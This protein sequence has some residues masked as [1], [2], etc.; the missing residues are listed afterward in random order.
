MRLWCFQ[1]CAL[2]LALIATAAVSGDVQLQEAPASWDD[3]EVV[4]ER[5]IFSRSR[6]R[7]RERA[8][9]QDPQAPPRPERYIVLRGVVQ[10]GEELIAFLEDGRTGVTSR[11][12][13]GDAIASGRLSGIT[14]DSVQYESDGQT[15]TIEIGKNLVGGGSAAAS[16]FD[17][18][19]APGAATSEE[20]ATAGG[21]EAAILERLR[22]KR[23]RELGE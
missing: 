11:A 22:Q 21:N 20:G 1:Y 18:F 16:P 6:G 3:Y 5:N 8:G 17:L 12:R 4:V 15:A 9:T 23:E 14:L 7:P 19:E 13:I 2:T 10:Q